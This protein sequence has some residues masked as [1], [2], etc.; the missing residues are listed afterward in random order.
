MPC[1]T[2]SL[3]PSLP[4]PARA[5]ENAA[6]HRGRRDFEPAFGASLSRERG[7]THV[8]LISAPG[9]TW[10][11][12]RTEPMLD[13]SACPICFT[14]S[15]WFELLEYMKKLLLCGGMVLLGRGSASQA[16]AARPA[17]HPAR[18]PLGRRQVRQIRQCVHE[19]CS[20]IHPKCAKTKS[21]RCTK[22]RGTC[23]GNQE[24]CLFSPK[25]IMWYVY[26]KSRTIFS[27][28]GVDAR[29]DFGVRPHCEPHGQLPTAQQ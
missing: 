11:S 5:R 27:T 16:S 9:P 4:T 20:C 24:S 17:S 19:V 2:Q 12:A 1:T 23:R 3:P 10:F 18:G 26:P 22:P 8:G 29:T 21:P 28:F 25:I 13:N 7:N 15:F 6:Q 14:A